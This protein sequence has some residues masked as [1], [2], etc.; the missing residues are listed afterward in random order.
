MSETQIDLPVQA[1]CCRVH[2]EVFRLKWPSG[3]LG[4]AITVAQKAIETSDELHEATG[5]DSQKLN[6]VVA[7]FGPL[8][9]LVTP[10]IR[11]EAYEVGADVSRASGWAVKALC[12][13]CGRFRV[14]AAG[15]YTIARSVTV[16]RHVCFDC[17]AALEC[18]T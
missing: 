14:G 18:Q 10:E 17:V 6:A 4:F 12:A 9:R 1:V 7:E 11:R 13:S 8:C 5:G 3:Y 15:L 16:E 2:G